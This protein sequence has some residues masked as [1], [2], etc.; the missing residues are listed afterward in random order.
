MDHGP[1]TNWGADRASAYKTRLGLW[2]FLVYGIVYAGFILIN[3][4]WPQ[5]MA[6]A[7]GSLNLAVA[8]GFALIV[9]AL[10]MAFIY[11]K[12]CHNAEHAAGVADPDEEEV[13]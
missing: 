8:Y 7:I 4:V 9:L 12:L 5:L 1:S 2:M 11:N 10:I 13:L 6:A 3:T